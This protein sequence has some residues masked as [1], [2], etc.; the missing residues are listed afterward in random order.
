MGEIKSTLDIIM[1]KAKQLE[2]TQEEKETIRRKE[3]EDQAKGMV[4]KALDG[5]VTVDNIIDEVEK[6]DE[7]AQRWCREKIAQECRE[8]LDFE[9][10]NAGLLLLMNKVCGNDIGQVKNLINEFREQMEGQAS[11]LEAQMRRELE[12]KGIKGSAIVA[13][14]RAA[15]EWASFIKEHRSD[16]KK[17]LEELALERP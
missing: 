14:Y 4:Q 16:F 3:I 11:R 13:N 8:R 17:R 9:K 2:V 6:M 7:Q 10:D 5:I 1:E 15:P 12:Q